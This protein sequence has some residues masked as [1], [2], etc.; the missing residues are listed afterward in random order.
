MENQTRREKTMILPI[1]VAQVGKPCPGLIKQM[2][3]YCTALRQDAGFCEKDDCFPAGTISQSSYQV[4]M[5]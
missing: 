2:I 4:R 3:P 5:A 1:T